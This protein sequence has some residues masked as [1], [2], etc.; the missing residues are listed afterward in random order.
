MRASYP[1]E[2]AA[3][4]ERP[5]YFLAKRL[6]VRLSAEEISVVRADTGRAFTEKPLV[7]L[8]SVEGRWLNL[9]IGQAAA[10]LEAMGRPVINPFQHDRV[11]VG[12]FDAAVALL[13]GATRAVLGGIM[14]RPVMIVH[15][16]HHLPSPLAPI[17]Y[18]ALLDIA[19]MSGAMGAAIHEG[20]PLSL[21]E[22]RN[23]PASE[24]IAAPPAARG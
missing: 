6:Y 12:D 20:A 17:E 3:W 24:L 21:E 5:L 8:K 16:T 4:Y 2:M 15:P 22:V 1:T 9:E 18:R 14:L 10:A 13:R 7:A 23:Y 19:F 11:F